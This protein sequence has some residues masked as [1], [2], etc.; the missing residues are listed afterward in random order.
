MFLY[1]QSDAFEKTRL[2][3][4]KQGYDVVEQALVDGSIK[5]TV[6]VGGAA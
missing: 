6:R 5:L 2:E 3:A 4:R 1:V